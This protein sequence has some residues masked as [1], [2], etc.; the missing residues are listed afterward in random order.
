MFRLHDSTHQYCK[1][2][3]HD[4]STQLSFMIYAKPAQSI[5]PVSPLP[6][7]LLSSSHQ[8]HMFELKQKE[9]VVLWNLVGPDLHDRS[10]TNTRV[11]PLQ[12]R[13]PQASGA[14][15]TPSNSGMRTTLPSQKLIPSLSSRLF[16]THRYKRQESSNKARTCSRML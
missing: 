15:V 14:A 12:H 7:T 16:A 6:L 13:A 4:Y 11:P 2:Q 10:F 8:S 3:G 5:S 9:F 1:D